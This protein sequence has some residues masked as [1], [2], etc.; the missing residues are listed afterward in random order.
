MAC[1]P[2]DTKRADIYRRVA[3]GHQPTAT[4]GTGVSWS[5]ADG[6][7]QTSTK[8]A[9]IDASSPADSHRDSH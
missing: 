3:K 9:A 5:A 2:A 7:R 1:R 4:G 6:I 8:V